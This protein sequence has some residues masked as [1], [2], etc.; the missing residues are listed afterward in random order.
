M[1]TYKVIMTESIQI[2]ESK[3]LIA[4]GKAL[5]KNKQEEVLV[6]DNDGNDYG[7]SQAAFDGNDGKTIFVTDISGEE[8]EIKIKDIVKVV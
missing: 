6:Q 2:I 3:I 8:V 5:K 1:K 4:I 7:V